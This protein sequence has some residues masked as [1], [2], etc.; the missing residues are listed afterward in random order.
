GPDP[1]LSV[2]PS[3]ED[4]DWGGPGAILDVGLTG[5]RRDALAATL[6]AEAAGALYLRFIRA[7]AERVAHLEADEIAAWETVEEALR[8]YEDETDEPFPQDPAVQLADVLR[9]MARVWEGT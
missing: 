8:A 6:G 3:S 7:Y 9:S 4:P 2:R 1:V 5:A